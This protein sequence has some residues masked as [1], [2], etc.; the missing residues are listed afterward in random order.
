MAWDRGICR[1]GILG[2]I[3]PPALLASTHE[4]IE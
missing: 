3:V 2:L 1:G 4:V